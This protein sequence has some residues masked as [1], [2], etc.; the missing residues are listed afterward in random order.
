MSISMK[1][2]IILSSPLA[3]EAYP[4]IE[5][6]IADYGARYN[7]SAEDTRVELY[8]YPAEAFIPPLGAFLLLR[9]EGQTIAGGA[10]MSHD[11]ETAEL[12]RIWCNTDFRR[13]GLARRIVAALEEKAVELGYTRLYLTTGFRQPEAVALY[14]SL[15]Y[16]PLFDVNVDQRLYESLPF[17]KLVGTAKNQPSTT[18]LRA[19]GTSPEDAH[20][21]VK[22]IKKEQEKLIQKRLEQYQA[23]FKQTIA[24]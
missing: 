2:E 1:D 15:G 7:R 6:L 9:R 10:F 8:R 24:S 22:A 12:K 13:Q 14:L 5:G 18:P 23:T 11:D 19:P 17:E 16:R 3:P 4:V 21:I 20:A